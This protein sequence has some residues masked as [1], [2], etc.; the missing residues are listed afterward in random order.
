MLKIIQI[1]EKENAH[2]LIELNYQ[3]PFE[4]LVAVILSAQATDKHVNKVTKNL[5]QI[6]KTPEDIVNLGEEKLREQIKSIG[7]FNAKA[8]NIYKMAQELI[9]KHHSK[10]PN[11]RSDLEALSGVGRKSAN[12]ILN[13]IFQLPVIAVD[14]HVFRVTNRLL[15]ENLKTPQK[16][17][18]RLNELIP[19]NFRQNVSNL[20]ILHGRYVCKAQKPDCQNCPVK[21]YCQFFHKELQC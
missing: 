11:L 21:N 4:L 3:T 14:T 16:V 13:T 15:G 7:L 9:T 10:V 2:P 8:K 1:L 6:V 12:V 20:L 18:E 17:E 19:E 5:F